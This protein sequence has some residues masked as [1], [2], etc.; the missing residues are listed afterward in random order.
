[1]MLL[2]SVKYSTR[3]VSFPQENIAFGPSFML[4]SPKT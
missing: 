2:K 3:K 1:M 4:S